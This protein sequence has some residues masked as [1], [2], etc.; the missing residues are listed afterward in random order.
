MELCGNAYIHLLSVDVTSVN[1]V[2]N[3]SPIDINQE[4][5]IYLKKY[6]L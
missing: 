4:K 1:N 3:M 6:L 5:Y 2:N